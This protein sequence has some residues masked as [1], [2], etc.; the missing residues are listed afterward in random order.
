MDV[1]TM[2]WFLSLCETENMR[3]TA[4][5]E[6][7]NQSTLSRAL[8]R[9]EA[10]LG[11]RLF[12]RHGRRLA[13]SRFG[14]L[15]RDHAARALGELDQA[16]RRIDALANPDTGLI[17]LG[18]LHS[19]GRWLVPE[20]LRDYRAVTPGIRFE[21]RQGFAREIYGWLRE[22]DIDAALVTPPPDGSGARWFRLREQQL[23]LA[24]PV[25]HPLAGV[26]DLTLRHLR[27]EPFIAFA[28]TTDLRRVIDGLCQAAGFEPVI[29]F[30]S[31]EIAT[32]R[33]LIG[34]GL[35]V[36][37][38]PRPETP[39]HDDP[40]YRPLAPAQHRP[41]GL[42]WDPHTDPTPATARFVE[43]VAS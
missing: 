41:I 22:G 35:G 20:V 32:V 2:R 31:E 24:L 28:P 10:D 33:G 15:F 37:V 5:V 7:I 30:E 18:F 39:E 21:L 4:A 17:R 40:V 11:V 6:R 1:Q 12:H 23:C 25:D 13:V 8:A 36:G 43:H 14:A 38:L 26:P 19:V 9:L 3:D 34:A 16:R 27:D 29:A 42:A